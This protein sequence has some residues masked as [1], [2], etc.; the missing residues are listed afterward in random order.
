[1]GNTFKNFGL[2]LLDNIRQGA[3]DRLSEAAFEEHIVG[4]EKATLAMMEAG[5]ERSIIIN[6]LQKHWNLRLSEA[7]AFVDNAE[8]AD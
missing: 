1:M 7:T 6:M 5:V 2:E 4:I 8:N 3:K